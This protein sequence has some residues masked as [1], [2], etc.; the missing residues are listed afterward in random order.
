[1]RGV[2]QPQIVLMK[3]NFLES[4]D[5]IC[6]IF[7]LT[8]YAVSGI[9]KQGKGCVIKGGWMLTLCLHCGGTAITLDEKVGKMYILGT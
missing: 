7:R 8:Q 1:L 5:S 3:T 4:G 2:M 9:I 6:P